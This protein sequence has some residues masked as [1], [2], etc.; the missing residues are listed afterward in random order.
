M[1]KCRNCGSDLEQ[2][3]LFCPNCG[4]KQTVESQNNFNQ[5]VATLLNQNQIKAS[6]DFEGLKNIVVSMFFKPID[7]AKEYVE[8]VN[9]ETAF[10]FALILC[11]I[12]G[13]LGIWKAA[14]IMSNINKAIIGFFNNLANILILFGENVSQSDIAEIN[15]LINKVKQFIEVPY[16]KIFFQNFI[17]IFIL[18]VSI[19]VITYILTNIFSNSKKDVLTIFKISTIIFLP[20]TYLQVL[21]IILSYL[22]F[23][24]GVVA[25]LFG[26]IMA[27]IVLNELVN[28]YLLENKNKVTYITSVAILI[29]LIVFSICFSK[30]TRSNVLW[31]VKHIRDLSN[32]IGF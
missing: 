10:V 20:V 22:S 29:G 32:V 6:F 28:C 19:F 24:A 31:F 1:L 11:L 5:E 21:S 14:Q 26:I 15:G 27:I 8:R 25:F 18:I 7:A 2:G 12:Q 13:L 4:A 16:G 9:K 3:D 23:Y 30:F 17:T